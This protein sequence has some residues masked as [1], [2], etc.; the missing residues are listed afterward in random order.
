MAMEESL[1]GVTINDILTYEHPNA[2]EAI[3]DM[4]TDDIVGIQKNEEMQKSS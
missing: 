2:V 4:V 3:A 1:D